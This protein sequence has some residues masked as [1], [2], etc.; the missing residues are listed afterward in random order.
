[1]SFVLYF[2]TTET[3]SVIIT[4]CASLKD[5]Q[6]QFF[7]EERFYLV[8]LVRCGLYC[9]CVCVHGLVCVR[10]PVITLKPPVL[11]CIQ[12]AVQSWLTSQRCIKDSSICETGRD[13]LPGLSFLISTFPPTLSSILSSREAWRAREK[14]MDSSLREREREL[15]AFALHHILFFPPLHDEL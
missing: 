9:S 5:R 6:S 11:W 2:S 12:G 7:F 14:V 8:A 13:E 15:L 4:D 1:M 10:C 3:L